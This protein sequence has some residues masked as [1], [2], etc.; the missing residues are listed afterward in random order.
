MLNPNLEMVVRRNKDGVFMRKIEGGNRCLGAY[1]ED[2][3]DNQ[4]E[5]FNG[6]NDA[7]NLRSW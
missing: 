5:V 7:I 2:L 1:E 6:E 4:I 3:G